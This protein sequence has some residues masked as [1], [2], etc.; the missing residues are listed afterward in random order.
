LGPD[1][2]SGLQI[3]QKDAMTFW[4]VIVN[5]VVLF[6]V[7]TVVVEKWLPLWLVLHLC[8]LSRT[9]LTFTG[10]PIGKNICNAALLYFL[11]CYSIK[12]LC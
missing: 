9:E 11:E 10:Q 3:W 1:L 5:A 8:N 4:T 6:V 12:N 2:A 7:V